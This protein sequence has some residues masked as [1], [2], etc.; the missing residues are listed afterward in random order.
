MNPMVTSQLA[1]VKKL[2]EKICKLEYIGPYAGSSIRRFS[3]DGLKAYQTRILESVERC[4]GLDIVPDFI[5]LF[6]EIDRMIWDKET[7]KS[8]WRNK[9]I[10]QTPH[11]LE[12]KSE[13]SF[14]GFDWITCKPVTL[15][16]I[17]RDMKKYIKGLKK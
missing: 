15:S 1:E 3:C 8:N 4:N 14:I 6:K 17:I 13:Y 11:K 7:N 16:D 5:M 9:N 2:A 10:F 12:S